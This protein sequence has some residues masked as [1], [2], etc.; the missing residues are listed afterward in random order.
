MPCH[1][2]VVYCLPFLPGSH[3]LCATRLHLTLAHAAGPDVDINRPSS[4]HPDSGPLT[5]RAPQLL[6]QVRSSCT[7]LELVKPHST[8]RTPTVTYIICLLHPSSHIV[9]VRVWRAGGRPLQELLLLAGA[10]E[11]PRAPAGSYLLRRN[12]SIVV[13]I[14]GFSPCLRCLACVYG[15]L[16]AHV[17]AW[18]ANH[19]DAPPYAAPAHG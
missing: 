8:L 14:D 5:R 18:S 9:G 1:K 12:T 10:C 11:S 4:S 2:C 7:A 17:G 19:T 6:E 15:A 16:R 13:I 3:E